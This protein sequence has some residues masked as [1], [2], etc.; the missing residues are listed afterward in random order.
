MELF[1]DFMLKLKLISMFQFRNIIGITMVGS[2]V[3]G[4]LMGYYWDIDGNMPMM[5]GVYLIID[6]EYH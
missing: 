4:V 2:V 1:C 3:I 5:Q 6:W